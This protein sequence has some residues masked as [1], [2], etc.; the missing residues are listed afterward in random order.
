[1]EGRKKVCIVTG[2]NGG[3]GKEIALL[4]GTYGYDV[5]IA[6]RSFAAGNEAASEVNR[7]LASLGMDP[8][9]GDTGRCV[10]MELD[11]SSF[12]SVRNFVQGFR[13]RYKVLDRLFWNAGLMATPFMLTSEGYETQFQVNF[14]A[15]VLLY[16]ELKDALIAS[17]DGRVIL[18]ASR[19]AERAHIDTFIPERYRTAEGYNGFSAY[20]ESKLLQI[21]FAREA[22]L[23][24]PGISF[25]SCHPGVVATP[26]LYRFLPGFLAP[27][28]RLFIAF[29]TII[30]VLS[31]VRQGADTAVWL[32]ASEE[33]HPEKG[34]Y[35]ARRSIRAKPALEG[36]DGAQA[37][38][39]EGALRLLGK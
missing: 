14:L 20:A 37:S 2:G 3:I 29:F 25:Y 26:I 16:T 27:V 5:V 13:K 17:G 38:V 19:A 36:S 28:M 6:S 1:M 30:R 9:G 39:Y 32:A 11:L 12:D 10:F 33:P 4:M 7:R 21:L 24:E 35:F 8:N 15:Q 18:T 22:T 31:T 23:R 34:G